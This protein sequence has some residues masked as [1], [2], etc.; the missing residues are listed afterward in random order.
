M[1]SDAW[2]GLLAVNQH[3]AFYTMREEARHMKQRYDAGDPR[4]F[5]AVLR[6]PVGADR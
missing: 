2:H 6:Q 5:T 3:G 1:T 4:R